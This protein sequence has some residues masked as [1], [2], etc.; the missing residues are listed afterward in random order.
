MGQ[1][2]LT[3]KLEQATPCSHLAQPLVYGGWSAPHEM[4]LKMLFRREINVVSLNAGDCILCYILFFLTSNSSLVY[5]GL[6]D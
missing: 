5:I 3:A 6:L 1:V 2:Y 4:A